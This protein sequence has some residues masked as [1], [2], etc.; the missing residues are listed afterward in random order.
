[1][2]YVFTFLFLIEAVLKIVA[3]GFI[4]NSF[5]GISPYI[6]NAWNALDFFVVVSSLVD[7]GFS[8]SANDT[9]T[10]SLRRLKALRAIRALRPLRMVSRNKGLRIVVNAISR[11]FQL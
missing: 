8:E 5:P 2:D 3:L 1:L 9:D 10:G 7:F 4:H 11:Q 6:L